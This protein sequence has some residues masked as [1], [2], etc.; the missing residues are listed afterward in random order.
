[1]SRY[2][3][4]IFA[5]LLFSAVP[6]GP[7]E[8]AEYLCTAEKDVMRCGIPLGGIGAGTVEIRGDGKLHEW[9]IFNN[10]EKPIELPLA[11]FAT[12]IN[13]P[14]TEKAVVLQI[15][16]EGN[17]PGVKEI[18]YNGTFPVAR[19][20]Y[21]DKAIPVR[22]G[23]RAFSPFVPHDAPASGMPLAV[24]VFEATNSGS[25]PVE[26]VVMCAL[27]DPFPKL[28]KGLSGH[29]SIVETRRG[30]GFALSPR[31]EKAD[32]PPSV[33]GQLVMTTGMKTCTQTRT[34]GDVAAL[35]K[36]FAKD[37]HLDEKG[38]PDDT[39]GAICQRMILR[40]GESD[41]LTFLLTWYFPNQTD[42]SGATVGHFY[43]NMFA[44]GIA[45]ADYA[46]R[47]VQRLWKATSAF[48]DATFESIIPEWL[49]DAANSQLS[50]MFKSSW[51]TRDGSFGIWQ[52]MNCQGG[53]QAVEPT[54]YGSIPLALLFPELE[55]AALRLT[56]A[57][58][59]DKGRIPRRFA[60]RFDKP[61]GYDSICGA[62]RFVLMLYRDLVWTG[63]RRLLDDFW[64]AAKKAMDYVAS[65]DTDGNG[66]PEHPT[67]SGEGSWMLQGESSRMCS[68]WLAALRAMEEMA[69]IREEKALAVSF[70]LMYEEARAGF[71][72]RLWNGEYYRLF[73]DAK[74]RKKDDGCLL[75]AVNGE[76]YS[77]LVGLGRTLDASRV[78]CHLAACTR[79]NRM[80]VSPSMAY[81]KWQ[82]GWC[83]V[84]CTWPRGGKPPKDKQ[85]TSPWTGAEYA[86][87]SHLI[88]EGMIE[89]GLQVAEDV[90]RRYLR[91]GMPWN[92]LELGGHSQRA[93]DA[94]AVL[95]A[96]QGFRYNALSKS[97]S[98][99]AQVNPSDFRV[100]MAAPSGWGVLTAAYRKNEQHVTVEMR[101]GSIV[102][103]ELRIEPSPAITSR[104]FYAAGAKVGG[105]D[106]FAKITDEDG[107]LVLTFAQEHTIEPGK[108][109]EAHAVGG[110]TFITIFDLLF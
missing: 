45:A 108:P 11:F 18:A 37:G 81:V 58:T 71:D 92:H 6:G 77:R 54:F 50:T 17:L 38:S 82:Q 44:D 91:A 15:K 90:Y 98:V 87:A 73:T 56:A 42:R 36:D 19:L 79:Y 95:L 8:G 43:Q 7:G 68:L 83:S 97:L 34:W 12:Y 14:T 100:V 70:R 75:G 96:A 69:K 66:L 25:V 93:M 35:W 51:W 41:S 48:N 62:P 72:D 78:K 104:G 57:H 67:K 102:V 24:F 32:A 46:E 1:M 74:E 16:P 27:P 13:A 88:Y 89:Q 21:L 107:T 94:W 99:A 40:P 2:V 31:E 30:T 33:R 109:L 23:L 59:D 9:Q 52:G 61:D 28:V 39:G 26:V 106:V 55:K 4:F 80:K 86:F 29:V 49:L 3:R 22:L 53:L 63:D 60:G 101:E 64:P 76:W 110:D 20:M 65:L 84:N 47:N 85:A 5:V 10:W 105:K 103:K